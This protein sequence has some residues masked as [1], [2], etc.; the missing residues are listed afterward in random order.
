MSVYYI[1]FTEEDIDLFAD[2]SYDYNPLHCNYEYARKTPYGERV[3]HGVLGI[4][5]CLKYLA[6]KIKNQSINDIR[7]QFWLP[8]FCNVNYEIREEIINSEN[9]EYLITDGNTKILQLKFVLSNKQNTIHEEREQ[10]MIKWNPL[11]SPNDCNIENLAKGKTYSGLYSVNH[12]KLFLLNKKFDIDYTLNKEVA[13]LLWSSYFIGMVVPGKQALFSS[14]EV[15]IKSPEELDLLEY[16]VHVDRFDMRFNRLT[17]TFEI[18]NYG[19]GSLSAFVRPE[20]QNGYVSVQLSDH[21]KQSLNGKTALITGA[22][23]GLGAMLAIY[24]STMGCKVI[25]NYQYSKNDAE[26]IRDN[27]ISNGGNVELWQGNCGDRKWLSSKKEQLLLKNEA[28][29]ILICNAC[30]SIKPMDINTNTVDRINNYVTDNFALSSVPIAVFLD[31]LNTQKG[32]LVLISSDYEAIEFKRQYP[33]Y[34]ATKAALETL[35]SSIAQKQQGVYYLIVKPPKMLTNMTNSPMGNK[36]SLNPA[37][38][39]MNI[40][41]SLIE[42]E[43]ENKFR[44]MTFK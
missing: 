36:D 13:F 19:S 37:T 26:A 21:L 11:E 8:L 34:V 10:K 2:C 7:V 18:S 25:I 27:I 14:L 39:A 16:E 35:V 42:K 23:R 31:M 29:D 17:M 28:I 20:I 3:V 24:L 43:I 22:S 40:C 9:V 33:Q 41:E 15:H 30:G 5:A 38:V 1:T 32:Y 4:L 12:D 6:N 44:Y